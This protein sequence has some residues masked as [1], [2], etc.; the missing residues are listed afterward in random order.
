MRPPCR[1]S[2]LRTR[3]RFPISPTVWIVCDVY[4]NDLANVRLGD[5][6]EITLNAY[7]GRTFKGRVSNIGAILDPNIRTAKVRIEVAEP[8]NHAAGHV[9]EGHLPGPDDR[10]AHDRSG[11]RRHA[12]AR[13]RFCLRPRARQK[14]SPGGG[15]QRRSAAGQHDCRRSSRGS[16]QGN[17]W[18]RTP[19][20]S[21]TCCLSDG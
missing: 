21:T 18:L 9:R 8:G 14:V 2:I 20:S 11:L 17:K 4:E 12:H 15:G 3:S 5:T 10:D 19:W 7:P 1:R 13:S 6:A 16:S